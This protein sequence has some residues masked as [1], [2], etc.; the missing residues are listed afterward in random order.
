MPRF[1]QGRVQPD[2]FGHMTVQKQFLLAQADDPQEPIARF[3]D[4]IGKRFG[5]DKVG[6]GRREFLFQL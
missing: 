1:S 2:G 3:G 6:Q 5:L 4:D